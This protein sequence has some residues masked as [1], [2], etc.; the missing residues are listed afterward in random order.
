VVA[1]PASLA[2]LEA[3]ALAEP[4]A[5]ERFAVWADAAVEHGDVRRELIAEVLCFL[6]SDSARLLESLTIAA[7]WPRL[8][9]LVL[10]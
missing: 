6:G 10:R 4:D 5:A 7:R 2:A 8:R 9:E 1:V 3:D